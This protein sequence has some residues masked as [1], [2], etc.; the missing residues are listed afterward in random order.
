[1]KADDSMHLLSK[2]SAALFQVTGLFGIAAF[3]AVFL[4][5][6]EREGIWVRV[7][8]ASNFLLGLGLGGLLLVALHYVTGA[9]W[10]LPLRRIEEAMT[11]GIP[12]ASIGMIAVLFFFPSLYT[13]AG[14]AY[15]PASHFRHFWMNRPF[16]LAR[17]LIY[18]AVWILFAVVLVNNSRR[19]DKDP[20]PSPTESNRR[21]SAFFLAVFGVTCWLATTDWLMSLARNWTSTIFAVYNFSGLFLSALA[22]VVLLVIWLRSQ[23][24][25]GEVIHDNHLHDLGT[26]LFSISSLWMYTW[27]CQYLLIWFVNYSEETAYLRIRWQNN[28]PIWLYLD[29][30][31]NWAVP[32]IVL[33]FRSAKRSPWLMG[34]VAVL[35]L[36]GR[37]ID[38]SLMILPTQEDGSKLPGLLDAGMLLGTIGVFALSLP[39]L[40][41]TASLVP[42][43][44]PLEA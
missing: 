18:L 10:S 37:W 39:F 14:A 22:G 33:L 40:L 28:W 19:Q 29:L 36:I 7:L 44:E 24:S 16:F 26:L 11:V 1:M 20:D 23:D 13:E 35:V 5:A 9:H 2:K 21:L 43:H 32:F 41:R 25:M 3:I 27:F 15:N 42:I 4:Q 34:T 12:L 17:S 8:L 31:F 6:S 38:L 30:A